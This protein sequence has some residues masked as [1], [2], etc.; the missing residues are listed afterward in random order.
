MTKRTLL[1]TVIWIGCFAASPGSA[2]EGEEGFRPI[3]NGK[4]L[5]GWDGDPAIWSVQDGAI[6][7]VTS[8]EKPLKKN[9]FIIW[10]QGLVDDFE[11]RLSWRIVN[12]N[13]GIQYR[14]RDHGDWV[15]GGY[16]ADF[17]AGERYSGILYEERG[18]GILALR[19]KK[20]RITE[21]G[22]KVETGTVG[23]PAEL[24]A[25]IRKEEWNDYTIIARGRQLIHK[26]NGRITIEVTDEQESRR[27]RSGVLAFQAHVGPPM[28][29]QFKNVRL[30]RLPLAEGK[31][32][33]LIGGRDSHGRG[34]HA[35]GPGMRLFAGC[36]EDVPG[37]LPAVYTGGWPKDPTAIDNADAIVI[38]SDGG[39]GHPIIPHLDAVA[40]RMA[41]GVGLGC[42]HYAVEVPKGPA[43]DRLVEWIGGYFETWWS[44]N[45]HW[46]MKEPTI[47]RDHPVARGVEPFDFNDEWYYHMRFR[48][49]MEGVTP[50]LSAVPPESTL[51]RGDGPHSN[52]PHVRKEAGKPQVLCWAATR[53][54]GGRGFGFTGGHFH[55][56]WGVDGMRRLVLNAIVWISG[57]EVPEGGVTCAVDDALLQK[58]LEPEGSRRARRR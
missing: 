29:V 27:A 52:N 7:A 54:D 2:A 37:I 51:R 36:L 56:G 23:D 15:V 43:G 8:A 47:A 30:K 13:S 24:Q 26:I 11:L 42:I 20:V 6:T 58:T 49:G 17:E 1:Y 38:Y 10:R 44:V 32:V 19:G 31:K 3:F 25:A 34:Q 48:E 18:R 16:Q 22:K 57:L 40:E 53:P 28:T 21:D 12:G 14:S 45:P 35:H 46:H 33:V 41:K 5:S 55:A 9:T 50:I 39:G 4:D